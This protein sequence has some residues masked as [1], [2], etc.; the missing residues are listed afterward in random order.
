MYRHSCAI[1]ENAECSLE[2]HGPLLRRRGHINA[3]TMRNTYYRFAVAGKLV[4]PVL[5]ALLLLVQLI[6]LMI[7]DIFGTAVGVCTHALDAII[8]LLHSC[9]S[10]CVATVLR[11]EQWC[12]V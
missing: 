7:F 2:R 6:L 9:S 1:D 5:L 10:V 12:A 4:L 8:I 11:V 3:L